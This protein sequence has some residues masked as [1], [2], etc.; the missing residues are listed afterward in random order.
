MKKKGAVMKQEVEKKRKASCD[1]DE[2]EME[3]KKYMMEKNEDFEWFVINNLTIDFLSSNLFNRSRNGSKMSSPDVEFDHDVV[4]KASVFCFKGCF[5]WVSPAN[6]KA[7]W[8]FVEEKRSEVVKIRTQKVPIFKLCLQLFIFF[9]LFFVHQVD[10][11][12]MAV[13][14]SLLNLVFACWS[15]ENEKKAAIYFGWTD[16]FDFRYFKD[17]VISMWE[18]DISSFFLVN[19]AFIVRIKIKVKVSHIWFSRC[20]ISWTKEIE[21]FDSAS[22]AEETFIYF[23]FVKL[24]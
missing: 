12:K 23:F 18:T 7:I 1:S 4:N 5:D 2:D 13:F 11:S 8:S 14:I 16:A 20:L 9:R 15:S 10:M 17:N 6:I 3:I 22:N 21:I 24:E 19:D